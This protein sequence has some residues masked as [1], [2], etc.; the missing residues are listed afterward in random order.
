MIA[1]MHRTSE[2]SATSAAAI[3]QRLERPAPEGSDRVNP[4]I[5]IESCGDRQVIRMIIVL[6]DHRTTLNTADK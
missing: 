2:A 6:D 3:G 4:S 5:F 1:L